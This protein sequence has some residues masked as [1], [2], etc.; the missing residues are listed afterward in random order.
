MQ[1]RCRGAGPDVVIL[2]DDF[3]GMKQKSCFRVTRSHPSS[4]QQ[5]QFLSALHGLGAARGPQLIEGAGAVRL[6]CVF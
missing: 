5:A 3:S 6:Y 4:R 1:S 2:S